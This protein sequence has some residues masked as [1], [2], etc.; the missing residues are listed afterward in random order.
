MYEE[1]LQVPVAWM[2]VFCINLLS[3]SP[4]CICKTQIGHQF[5]LFSN[6]QTGHSFVLP[7]AV[8]TSP[9]FSNPQS[10]L[11]SL[12][13]EVIQHFLEC[14]KSSFVLSSLFLSTPCPPEHP[15]MKPHSPPLTLIFMFTPNVTNSF[16]SLRCPQLK[17]YKS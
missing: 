14:Q 4:Q 2:G 17:Y 3:Q 5:N 10:P 9:F 7:L 13:L 8:N 11:P 16:R 12:R 6:P 15:C 1:I